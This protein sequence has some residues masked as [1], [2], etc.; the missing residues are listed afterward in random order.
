M[1][2]LTTL[3]LT[4]ISF[5]TLALAAMLLTES[6]ASILEPRGTGGMSADPCPP[7]AVLVPAHNEARMIGATLRGLLRQVRAGDRLLVVADNCTDATAEIARALGADVIERSDQRRLGK[8]YALEFG[9]NHLARDGTPAAVVFVDADC[10]A[11]EGSIAKLAR[12][13]C[14]TQRPVQASYL[15]IAG[16]AA[17]L[18]QRLSAFAIRLKNYVRPL[19][20][21]RIGLACP[22]T[23]SGFALPARLLSRAKRGADNL[24]EDLALGIDLA[25]SGSPP[26]FVSSAKIVSPLAPSDRA[27]VEQRKRWERGYLATMA[28]AAPSLLRRAIAHRDLR[29]LGLTLDLCIPPLALLTVVMIGL[30]AI[31]VGWLLIAGGALPMTVQALAV[32]LL[33]ATIF[34]TWLCY[35]RDLLGAADLLSA[36][37]YILNKI[38]MYVGFAFRRRVSWVRSSRE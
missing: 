15:L 11:S 8:G 5:A 6:I 2:A 14:T 37:V 27:H 36:P 35:G 19:G 31:D 9:I 26:L 10:Q 24:V 12:I 21:R 7:F 16:P 28:Q 29:L 38:P 20:C 33:N 34:L 22:I 1:I 17:S 3:F 23:G 30:T 32:V 4:L 18:S 25:L 13:A